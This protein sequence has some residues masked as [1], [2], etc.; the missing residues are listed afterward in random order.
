MT[1][2]ISATLAVVGP[3]LALFLFLRRTAAARLGATVCLGAAIGLGCGV[4]S[5]VWWCLLQLP[6]GSGS[7]LLALDAG[8]WALVVMGM[9]A[10]RRRVEPIAQI[11]HSSGWH[12]SPGVIAAVVVVLGLAGL[13]VT[14]YA[15]TSV[16]AP[17]GSWDA[18]AVW[19]VR[20]RFLFLGVPAAWHDAFVPPS[21]EVA[22]YPMLVPAAV[23]RLWTFAG[24]D[25]VVVPVALAAAFA[26]AVVVVAAAPSSLPPAWPRWRRTPTRA[27]L[28][29][30]WSPARSAH[31][32]KAASMRGTCHQGSW[33]TPK[34]GRCMPWSS[35]CPA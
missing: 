32:W 29:A 13:A 8:V 34:P 18:W 3:V 25:S 7:V 12:R 6:V 14:T 16:A 21:I 24:A 5:L 15:A 1:G 31:W 17:H 35:T 11:H 30:T 9:L 10:W 33:C 20:A 23:A 2:G 27:S 4:S 26:A 19:N 22:D 28:S